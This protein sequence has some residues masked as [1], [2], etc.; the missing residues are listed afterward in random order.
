VFF[1]VR[2][3]LSPP[4][5]PDFFLPKPVAVRFRGAA[6]LLLRAALEPP[7]ERL[8]GAPDGRRGLRSGGTA[9][10]SG[11]EPFSLLGYEC[12]AAVAGV[13]QFVDVGE[14]YTVTRRSP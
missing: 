5:P 2:L 8:R 13:E 4:A 14:I 12:F 6:E 3:R 1:D 11:R 10:R 9:S 7:A